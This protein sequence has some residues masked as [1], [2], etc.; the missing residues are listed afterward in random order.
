MIR[1]YTLKIINNASNYVLNRI[2]AAGGLYFPMSDIEVTVPRDRK[3]VRALN[4]PIMTLK[5][6]REYDTRNVEASVN[7]THK[8]TGLLDVNLKTGAVTF[9]R[10]FRE[11]ENDGE[12]TL[13]DYI[14][15]KCALELSRRILNNGGRGGLRRWQNC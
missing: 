15:F 14:F 1:T 12:F 10:M 7:Y 13:G 3:R 8:T 5:A 6:L 2:S 4:K 11:K 9:S